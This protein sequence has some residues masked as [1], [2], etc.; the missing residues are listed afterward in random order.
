MRNANRFCKTLH[1]SSC[2][3]HNSHSLAAKKQA[4]EAEA[5]EMNLRLQFFL[6][7]CVCGMHMKLADQH[8]KQIDTS[9]ATHKLHNNQ[10]CTKSEA[11][12]SQNEAQAP[13]H[14]MRSCAGSGGAH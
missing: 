8:T 11:N 5:A 2:G 9:K 7:L 6:S 14:K 12:H 3:D 1:Q 10:I 13:R 4:H